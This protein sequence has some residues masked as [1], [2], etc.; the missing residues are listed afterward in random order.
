METIKC[1]ECG[2]QYN[3][4][5]E[6]CT[7]CGCP[8]TFS[9]NNEEKISYAK[10]IVLTN[11]P[12]SINHK[13]KN[14]NKSFKINFLFKPLNLLNEINKNNIKKLNLSKRKKIKKSTNKRF[15]TQNSKKTI[16]HKKSLL[17]ILS[18]VGETEGLGD[19]SFENF[20][21]GFNK[22]FSENEI[23]N[24]LFVGTET[25][26]P[27]I[28]KVSTNYP[29]P[30]LCYRL[31]FL[32]IIFF[33]GFVFLYNQNQNQNIIPAI[34]FIGS[35]AVPISTLVL[36]FE[37][38]LRRNIPPWVVF[39][40]VLA[41]TILS[42]F[43]TE[44]LANNLGTIYSSSGAWF[45]ALLEEPAKLMALIFLT[46]GKKKYSYILNGLLLGAAV[47]CGFAAFETAGYALRSLAYEDFETM[48]KVIQIRGL[49]SP[50][51]H[52]VWTAVAGGALWRI[53]KNNKFS[54]KNIQTKKFIQ[55]FLFMVL[56]HAVWNSNLELPFN[57]KYII[58]G[59]VSWIIALSILNLGIKQLNQEKEGQKIFSSQ[60]NN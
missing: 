11:I 31:I 47:G 58:C 55:P 59:L 20:F 32:S 9:L 10:N 39:R 24:I 50:F 38:N 15:K 35:F 56:C 44:I 12:S 42:F 13:V 18:H 54:L 6:A 25:T 26:T 52:I 40:L 27:S 37:L 51:M 21:G 14:L 49:L 7:N 48:I 8:K 57:G 45:A 22:K 60:N 16:N 17:H 2:I 41:G 4:T 3:S 43:L 53:K 19:F 1:V 36:F 34:I 28:S 29:K 33:Y 46:N 30:W 5:N 23:V